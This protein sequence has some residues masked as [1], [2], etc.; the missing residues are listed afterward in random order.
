MTMADDTPLEQADVII[1]LRG[2]E[3][4]VTAGYALATKGL[5]NPL[6]ISAQSSFG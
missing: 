6:P 1:T 5:A 4:R 3:A 2:S